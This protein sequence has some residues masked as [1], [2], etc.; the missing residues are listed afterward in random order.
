V[1]EIGCG[2]GAVLSAL[3]DCGIGEILDGFELSA[4]AAAHARQKQ[5]N[6]VRRVEA[7]DGEHV[8]AADGAYDLAVLSHVV[9]HVHE[10]V[11]LLREAGRIARRVVVEVPL[12]ANW[13]AARPGK[14]AEAARIGHVHALDRTVVR[15]LCASAGLT[16]V[17]ELSDPLPLAHHA[18]FAETRQERARARVKTALRR[19]A[20]RVAPRSSERAFT[21]HYA[22]LLEPSVR[23]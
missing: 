5:V 1:V 10:P 8:P 18:F 7:Y 16:I 4:E 12:E 19:A 13:S 2:D 14:R 17:A 23:A 3:S 11:S 9:E 15:A 22:C 6:R 20:F 21:V